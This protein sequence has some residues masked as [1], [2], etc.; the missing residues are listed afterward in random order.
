MKMSKSAVELCSG[1]LLGGIPSGLLVGGSG[2][3]AWLKERV[4]G[5]ENKHFAG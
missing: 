1:G 3:Y 2:Q 4:L 5:S